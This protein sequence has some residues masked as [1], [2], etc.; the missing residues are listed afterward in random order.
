MKPILALLLLVC[1]TV[2]ES[3]AQLFQRWRQ[4]ATQSCPNGVCPTNSSQW[5]NRDGLSRSAHLEQ[6]HGIS[7]QGMNSAQIQQAQ[8]DYHNKY[9]AGHPVSG[10]QSTVVT[11]YTQPLIVTSTQPVVDTSTYELSAVV[12]SAGNAIERRKCIKAVMQAARQAKDKGTITSFQLATLSVLART[13]ATFEKIQLVIHETAIE[14]GLATATAIDWNALIA[15]I[16][17]LIPLIIQLIGLFGDNTIHTYQAT[18][19]VPHYSVDY[20]LAA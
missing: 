14:E 9:G 2:N 4:P 5:Y 7:T 13:P 20:Y 3:Q 6:V 11:T 15:F 10:V 12:V 16:E 17:K 8:N 19:Y 1:V 18:A